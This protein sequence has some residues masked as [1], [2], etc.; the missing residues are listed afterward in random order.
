MRNL[1]QDRV[2]I[3]VGVGPALGH[4]T[5]IACSA[6]GAKVVLAARTGEAMA[7][8]ADEIAASGGSA[9]CVP[10]RKSTRLNSS[11]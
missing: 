8:T 9:I 3:V 11:H 1:L 4:A 7:A 5:A 6:E 2:V 10:D